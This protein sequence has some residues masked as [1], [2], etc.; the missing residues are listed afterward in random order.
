MILGA[1]LGGIV[2]GMFKTSTPRRR[3]YGTKR[4]AYKPKGKSY[5]VHC[6]RK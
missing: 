4:R 6:R 5:Y 3:T 1:I 2:D